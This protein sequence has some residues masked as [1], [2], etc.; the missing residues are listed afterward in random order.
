MNNEEHLDRWNDGALDGFRGK[1]IA[2]DDVH[3]MDG[4]K[5]GQRDRRVRV[6]MPARPEGYY[7]S[8]VGTF[9]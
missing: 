2:S 9:D 6:V 3:Y 5:T 1:P 8:P 7:H 4:Y